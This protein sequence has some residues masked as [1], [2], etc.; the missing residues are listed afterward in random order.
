MTIKNYI[1]ENYWIL[2][3]ILLMSSI[4]CYQIYY[5]TYY[6]R[7]VSYN[8]KCY[9]CIEWVE[10]TNGMHGKFKRSWHECVK[11]LEYDC[12]KTYDSCSSVKLKD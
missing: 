8:T 10:K 7:T 9:K 3:P 5:H 6:C 2:I 12:V 1:K 11:H 4:V